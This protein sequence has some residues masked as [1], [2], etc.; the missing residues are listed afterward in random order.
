MLYTTFPLISILREIPEIRVNNVP[1]VCGQIVSSRR[2]IKIL[3]IIYNTIFQWICSR[4]TR[5][6][7]YACT[8][9]T[10]ISAH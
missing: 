8:L 1:D 7:T 9:Y 3:I 5:A 10:C 6:P 4:K 2:F